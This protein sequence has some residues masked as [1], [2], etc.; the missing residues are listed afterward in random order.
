MPVDLITGFVIFATHL[1]EGITGFGS[2]VLALPF[3]EPFISIKFA[4]KL[5]GILGFTMSLYLIF[6]SWRHIVWREF[7]FIALWLTAGLPIGMVCLQYLPEQ[8]LCTAL[9]L[10]MVVVG[11]RG[12]YNT[13]KNRLPRTDTTA[14]RSGWMRLLLFCGG[15]IQGAF[16]SAGPFV[17]IYA[18]RAL[19][20]KTLFRVTLSLVW[21][22]TN[23]LRL[24]TWSVQD[25]VYHGDNIW[26][27]A[28]GRAL[29]W[30][31]PFMI[32]G[33]VIGD[34]L[35]HRVSQRLFKIGVYAILVISGLLM[36][37]NAIG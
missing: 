32:L 16:G 12:E 19:Q 28:M 30:S 23:S 37:G 26:T 6:R 18:A 20:D 29:L 14:K 9:G 31:M 22:T 33:V 25:L 8:A 35:H 34:F 10:F 11:C 7:A 4:V 15:V 21:L 36:I 17:V 24:I 5:L 13:L 27:P 3:L 2:T 1:L